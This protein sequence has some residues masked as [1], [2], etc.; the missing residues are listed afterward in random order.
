VAREAKEAE[1]AAKADVE[2]QRTALR[3]VADAEREAQARARH[4]QEEVDALRNASGGPP[5]QAVNSSDNSMLDVVQGMQQAFERSLQAVVA[6]VRAPG[7]PPQVNRDEKHLYLGVIKTK[8]RAL[9]TKAR[10]MAQELESFFLPID[11]YLEAAGPSL[12]PAPELE[13]ARVSLLHSTLGDSARSAM[14]GTAEH[15]K[16]TYAL[17]K[18]AIE[19][20]FLT[21]CDPC[22]L[23]QL[24]RS[25]AMGPSESTKEFITRLWAL[26]SRI[27]DLTL[28]LQQQE[29]LTSLRMGHTNLQLR[30]LL[31]EK[32]PKTVPDAERICEEFEARERMGP[33]STKFAAAMTSANLS[34]PVDNVQQGSYRGPK[35]RGK[36]KGGPQGGSGG[37]NKGRKPGGQAN[38]GT[39]CHRCQCPGH[40]AKYCMASLPA[41]LPPNQQQ[42]RAGWAHSLQVNGLLNGRSSTLTQHPF[43]PTTRLLRSTDNSRRGRGITCRSSR[44]QGRSP[45]LLTTTSTSRTRF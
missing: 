34:V 16:A 39:V 24:V 1:R 38:S 13:K 7:G 32:Q 18:K 26:V 11:S 2:A 36:G 10:D 25:A 6:Q 29:I 30:N 20:R 17:Y 21:E 3:E 22:H 9:S 42:Q 33:V 19:K 4:L 27:P 43:I 5:A 41:V 15:Q 14:K 35:H 8:M 45:Q 31:M 44:T 28:D 12:A 37:N 40:I 23:T